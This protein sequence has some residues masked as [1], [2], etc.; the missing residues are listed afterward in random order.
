MQLPMTADVLVPLA[1]GVVVVIVAAVVL[2]RG[3]RRRP[4][5]PGTGPPTP[6]DW[7]GEVASGTAPVPVVVVPVR[8]TGPRTVAEAVAAREVAIASP[9]RAAR[10]AEPEKPDEQRGAAP[11]AEASAAGPPAAEAPVAEAPV[12][13]HPGAE[14]AAGEERTAAS[15]AGSSRPVAAAVAHALAARAAPSRADGRD[16]LLAVLLDDPVRALG[17]V[18]ELE[19]RRAKLGR[20]SAAM[21]GERAGLADVLRRL[22]ACGLRPDQLARLAGLADSEV[23]DLLG[24]RS[25][26]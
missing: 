16:R 8:R 2:P 22:E 5:E 4:E 9:P 17:A 1:V 12:A 7:T 19:E 21:T 25:P 10:E 15:P 24:R 23:R 14:R 18:A 3:L 13:E 20:L 11:V 6:S 26:A